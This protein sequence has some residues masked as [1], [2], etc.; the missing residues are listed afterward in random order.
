MELD[1]VPLWR[2]DHVEIKQLVL[3][4]AR[5]LYLPRLGDPSV[6]LGAVAQGVGLL[7]W[8]QDAFAFADTFDEAADRYRGL[9]AGQILPLTDAETP[10]L[11]VKPD[12][13]GK[14]LDTEAAPQPGGMPGAD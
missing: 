9:R 6:L 3:D 4:F 11:L 10:G 1:R 5:Y 14:Q 12:V 2:G 8:H 13:A 7:T